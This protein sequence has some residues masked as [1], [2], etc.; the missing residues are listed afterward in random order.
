MSI[1]ITG[2]AGFIG[3][4]F[5]KRFMRA[6]PR[7]PV[8]GIDDLSNGRAEVVPQDATLYRGSICDRELLA[9]VFRNHSPSYIFHFAALPR[10]AYSVEHPHETA[11]TNVLGTIALLEAAAKHHVKRFIF[12]SSSSVY[13]NTTQLPTRESTPANPRS[14]YALQKYLCELLCQQWSKL[15]GLD[16]VCLRYFNVYG[17]GQHGDSPY[18][19]VIAAWL[20]TL[21]TNGAKTPY[22]EG[23][24][25]QSRDFCYVDDVAEANILAMR[26]AKP[27]SGMAINVAG[28]TS[29]S[30]SDLHSLIERSTGKPLELERR[31]PRIGDV[32]ATRADTHKARRLLGF[33]ARTPLKEGLARTVRWFQD[34]AKN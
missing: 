11:E 25:G 29:V 10:V 26:A 24:G 30:L 32:R 19:T 14:P 18:S 17:P 7:V 34:S 22:L 13:G 15:Y 31:P 33:R 12:S 21:F 6:R 28:G 27:F 1:L 8:I 4:N 23:D 9:R 5:A 3:S 20:E 2:I 16:T